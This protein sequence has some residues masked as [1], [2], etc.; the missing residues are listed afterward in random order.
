M[1]AYVVSEIAAAQV[2][3]D[4]V[5]V[6]SVLKRVVHIHNERILELGQDLSLI[7][8]GLHAA[9]RDDASLAHLLHREVLLGLLTLDSPH[10]AEAALT[11]AKVVDEVRFG[12][13][14]YRRQ[15]IS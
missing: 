12:H 11:D 15:T 5:K 9:L 6:L 8:H 13:S 14:F 2:V 10:F 1:T 4:Q 7:D 3:H